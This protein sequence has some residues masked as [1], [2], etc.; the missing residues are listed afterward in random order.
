MLIERTL[1]FPAL[2]I[3][4]GSGECS[5]YSNLVK[6]ESM[7]LEPQWGE[8]SQTHPEWPQGSSS[9]LYNGYWVSFPEVKQPGHGANHPSPLAS[10]LPSVPAWNVMEHFTHL[11]IV[12]LVIVCP[13]FIIIIL[14]CW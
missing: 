14:C 11:P 7:V 8:I 9:L 1:H 13:Q 10:H 6:V 12:H 4:L 3:I 2:A 5:W